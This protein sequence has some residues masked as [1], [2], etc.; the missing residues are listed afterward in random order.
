VEDESPSQ[1]EEE[2]EEASLD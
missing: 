1:T 2:Q